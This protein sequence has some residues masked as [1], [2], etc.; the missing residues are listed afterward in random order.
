MKKKSH[1]EEEVDDPFYIKAIGKV[2]AI[3]LFGVLIV[4]ALLT[5]SF[6]SFLSI[7]I[8]TLAIFIALPFF[9]KFTKQ[10]F[11]YHFP[12]WIKVIALFVLF[13]IA[14]LLI[15]TSSDIEKPQKIEEKA[16]AD[17]EL[18]DELNLP[19]YILP[20]HKGLA[21]SAPKNKN[22][23]IVW[24]I[25][26]FVYDKV[27]YTYGDMRFY[28]NLNL[29]GNPSDVYGR[30]FTGDSFAIGEDMENIW[31][32]TSFC[33]KYD[34]FKSKIHGE[35]CCENNPYCGDYAWAYMRGGESLAYTFY[36]PPNQEACRKLAKREFEAEYG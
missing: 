19:E 27:Y 28:A 9:N 10:K 6:A 2:V 17:I 11:N 35:W 20:N 5:F 18:K 16:K 36:C 8:S 23:K 34:E 24:G 14:V 4:V 3:L 13:F 26:N 1:K 33:F 32:F 30:N 7:P 12:T 22:Y 29:S 15:G 31:G 21:I 25:K